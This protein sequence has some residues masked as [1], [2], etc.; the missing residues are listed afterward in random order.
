MIALYFTA[1]ALL[2]LLL[3]LPSVLLQEQTEHREF[4]YNSV[5][6][7]STGRYNFAYDTGHDNEIAHSLHMQYQDADGIVRGRYGYTDPRGKLRMVEY[8]AG[9]NGFV[10]RGDVGPD[11]FPHDQAP[12]LGSDNSQASLS[13]YTD[14]SS[15]DFDLDPAPVQMA[16]WD[17]VEDPM[18]QAQPSASERSAVES[19]NPATESTNSNDSPVLEPYTTLNVTSNNALDLYGPELGFYSDRYPRLSYSVTGN[20]VTEGNVE[21]ANSQVNEEESSRPIQENSDLN[22]YNIDVDPDEIREAA[23]SPV[24][25]PADSERPA[26]VRRSGDQQEATGNRPVRIRYYPRQTHDHDAEMRSRWTH[27]HYNER[28]WYPARQTHDHDA[29][30]YQSRS[31]YTHDHDAEKYKSRY[32][33]DHDAEKYKSRYT[34][35]HDAEK[36]RRPDHNAARVGYYRYGRYNYPRRIFYRDSH[37]MEP[38]EHYD[39]PVYQNYRDHQHSDVHLYGRYRNYEYPATAKPYQLKYVP[40]DKYHD[41]AYYW[42]NS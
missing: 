41:K 16:G 2:N 34:H 22:I 13:S 3:V 28:R 19:E 26:L 15:N 21:D 38:H 24:R 35:D 12:V 11:Q 10:A 6:D 17:P 40:S 25:R 31:R 23:G 42:T 8:E 18:G 36:Y 30:K 39:N 1:G 37:S 5:V 14:T 9:P 7:P 4:Q 29:E 33:H 20:D 27:D 32:T